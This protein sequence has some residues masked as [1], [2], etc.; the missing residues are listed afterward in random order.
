M[1]VFKNI[2]QPMPPKTDGRAVNQP[3]LAKKAESPNPAVIESDLNK[4]RREI[5]FESCLK[6]AHK[7]NEGSRAVIYQ[8]ELAKLPDEAKKIFGIS[9]EFSAEGI[10]GK[11]LKIY[12]HGKS[13][14]EAEMQKKAH[15]IIAEAREQEPEEEFAS[16]PW[17]YS[18]PE[19]QLTDQELIKKLEQDGISVI[20]GKVGIIIMDFI[21]GKDIA[22]H[23]YEKIINDYLKTMEKQITD[24]VQIP[25]EQLQIYDEIIK[26]KGSY[27]KNKEFKYLQAMVYRKLNYRPPENL[28][29]Q[30][31]PEGQL[32][33][34]GFRRDF[35]QNLIAIGVNLD[36]RVIKK[37]ENT[38]NA[39]HRK[40][41]YHN[42]INFRNIMFTFDARGEVIDVYLIDFDKASDRE[43]T[44]DLQPIGDLHRLVKREKN[45]NFTDRPHRFREM[46][47][48]IKKLLKAGETPESIFP[49]FIEQGNHE[50]LELIFI[51]LSQERVMSKKK[52]IKILDAVQEKAEKYRKP[53]VVNLCRKIL[54]KIN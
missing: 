27:D 6:T 39:L 49:Y 21:D 34:H 33:M 30:N 41:M 35:I 48:E 25:V 44:S 19:F 32:R 51:K 28:A 14:E 7:C 45:E 22:I 47:Q 53:Y 37:I 12:V 29:A 10:A 15:E 40:G 17:V 3:S 18:F 8:I 5:I 16:I 11:I 54:A 31:S 52:L 24:G 42:D 23:L 46:E 26:I 50:A 9:P 20:D 2:N 43:E 1:G 4:A 38:L 36:P 13:R